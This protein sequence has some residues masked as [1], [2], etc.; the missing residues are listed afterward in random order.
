MDFSGSQVIAKGPNAGM[1]RPQADVLIDQST[2]LKRILVALKK[3]GFQPV[4][5]TLSIGTMPNIMVLPNAATRKLIE[6]DQGNYYA[7][8]H[9]YRKGQARLDGFRI[10][11]EERRAG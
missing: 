11:W 9:N 10:A 6:S 7:L 3:N 5:A 4:C 8:G 2:E 1:P